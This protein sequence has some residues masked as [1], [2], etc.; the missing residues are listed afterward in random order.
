ML[1]R[2]GKEE[3][4]DLHKSG[5][6]V[7]WSLCKERWTSRQH[8]LGSTFHWVRSKVLT[9]G[10]VDLRYVGVC[11]HAINY[12]YAQKRSSG[13]ATTNILTH[14]PVLLRTEKWT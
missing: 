9:H 5:P 10:S 12:A 4:A 1:E 7:S 2:L 3:C 11:G 6:E 13:W 8:T 14:R